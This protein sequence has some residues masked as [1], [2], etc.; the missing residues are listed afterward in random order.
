MEAYVAKY[1]DKNPKKISYAL[2]WS[3]AFLIVLL[4]IINFSILSLTHYRVHTDP[5]YVSFCAISNFINCDS[6]AESPHSMVFGVPISVWGII[7]YLY[8]LAL[9][10]YCR[11]SDSPNTGIWSVIFLVAVAFTS[12]SLY[13]A[14]LSLFYIK[15]FCI[16]CIV[17]Y[18]TSFWLLF[19][20]WLV[21]KRLRINSL[22]V[23]IKR[24]LF[25]Y[26]HS[27]KFMLAIS[28]S[29]FILVFL[30]PLVYPKYWQHNGVRKDIAVHRGVTDDG[31][32][33]LGAVRPVLEII[34]YGDYQCA[35]CRRMHFHLRQ[36]VEMYSDKI[37]LIHRHFPMDHTVNPVVREPFHI[38]SGAL[39]LLAIYAAQHDK[40]WEMNDALYEVAG[41]GSSIDISSLSS[42]VGLDNWQL[43][44][45][46]REPSL[47]AK[48]FKDIQ[49]GLSLGINGTPAYYV[50]G[51]LFLGNIPS[52]IFQQ[53]IE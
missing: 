44:S 43:V 20:A 4:G 10:L 26:V 51:Q 47:A 22:Y 50:N 27:R 32:P 21:R 28:T 11:R 18:G 45:K 52:K 35:Q 6:V 42:S 29:F 3:S 25:D 15:S 46:L 41:A 39:A 48:L 40:F 31:D 16:L 5:N 17:A 2:Y 34:E 30:T 9:L 33:Y 7:G 13:L 38:G 19:I 49:S 53:Y 36:L 8:I 1:T 12:C 23:D 24:S 37:R 14:Y